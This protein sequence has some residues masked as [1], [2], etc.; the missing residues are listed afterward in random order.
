M[1]IWTR[2]VDRGLTPADREPRSRP[3]VLNVGRVSA[4]KGLDKLSVLQ[5][6]YTL[7]IIGDG[8]Y[9]KEARRLLPREF[10][11]AKRGIDLALLCTMLMYLCLPVEP[12]PLVWSTLKPWLAE[13][14]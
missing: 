13:H 7:V 6:D 10:V 14:R 5:D 1:V 12:I 3:M 11:G 9:M 8:P 4:E 2:G